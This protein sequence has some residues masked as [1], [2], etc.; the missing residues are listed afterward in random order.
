MTPTLNK[1]AKAARGK[2]PVT[3]TTTQS[4]LTTAESSRAPTA[5][6][7]PTVTHRVT[8]LEQGSMKIEQTIPVPPGQIQQD[9][10]GN[11]EEGD[12]DAK[13]N[14]HES[15][16]SSRSGESLRACVSER[17][18]RIRSG[19]NHRLSKDEERHDSLLTPNPNHKSKDQYHIT[20]Q[21][22]QNRWK[23][24][25][26]PKPLP[27]ETRENPVLP[28]LSVEVEWG[29]K[30][31]VRRGVRPRGKK[32]LNYFNQERGGQSLWE[33]VRESSGFQ[34]VMEHVHVHV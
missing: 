25:R 19:G 29:R 23:R 28:P 32:P 14:D 20:I 31:Y 9:A 12:D 17:C 3:A 11:E 15:Q 8:I 18:H 24:L 30:A 16:I 13:E 10:A 2:Q 21:Q 22:E 34:K 33:R 1:M 4:H 26:K 6:R 27:R 7:I 5:T